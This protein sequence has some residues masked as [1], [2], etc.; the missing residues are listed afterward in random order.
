VIY[1]FMWEYNTR[2]KSQDPDGAF[3][4]WW[5][6]RLREE[7]GRHDP[8]IQHL[9][10]IKLGSA[11]PSRFGA[12][13]VIEED[14]N[15]FWY[16]HS[17]EIVLGYGTPAV[18]ISSDF[19]FADSDFTGWEN[20][21][22]EP[23]RLRS[24]GQ[25][26]GHPIEPGDVRAM[27]AEGFH[28]AET[29]V[30]AADDTLRYYLQARWFMENRGVLDLK[31]RSR[32]E[33]LPEYRASERPQLLD[34]DGY[35]VGRNEAGQYGAFYRHPEGLAPAQAEI[36]IDVNA[37]GRFR[38]DPAGG[39]RFAMQAHGEDFRHGVLFTAN[40]PADR[41]Y[42]FRFADRNWNPPVRGGLIPG[43][44]EGISYAHWGADAEMVE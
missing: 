1:N 43:E 9:V 5:A 37:D 3:H 23:R 26:V 6:E 21:V 40:G 14:G 4:R 11:P 33:A 22:G 42:V 44:A 38:P 20:V 25:V 7:G 8:R 17:H 13:L 36:W 27:L 30:S 34:P 28:P 39:E 32:I 35:H 18:F 12:D 2:Q 15:G 16:S 19:A 10:S 31:P 29:W 41:A 24:N